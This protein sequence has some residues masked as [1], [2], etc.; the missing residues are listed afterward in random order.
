VRQREPLCVGPAMRLGR[1]RVRCDLVRVGLLSGHDVRFARDLELWIERR[2]LRRLHDG[3]PLRWLL[4][5]RRLHVRQWPVLRGRP[6]LL[7]RRVR[8]R[9]D[10][11]PLRLLFGHDVPP[12]HDDLGV[13]N[14]RRG[15]HLVWQRKLL[16]WCVQWMQ[17]FVVCEWLLLRIDLRVAAHAPGVRRVGWLVRVVRHR[18]RWLQQR[19]VHVR[20]RSGVRDRSALHGRALRVRLGLVRGWMLCGHDVPHAERDELRRDGSRVHG[21]HGIGPR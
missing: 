20:R 3:W 8:V 11:V 19:R 1:V 2:R 5:E 15:V 7:G 12:R 9:S 6:T 17:S 13:W 4:A 16:G 18:R 21:L 10:V 14:G